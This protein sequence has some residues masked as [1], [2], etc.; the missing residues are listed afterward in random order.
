MQITLFLQYAGKWFDIYR[1]EDGV[2]FGCECVSV[3]FTPGETISMTKCCQRPT[4]GHYCVDGS[5]TVSY[6]NQELTEGRL[7]ISYFGRKFIN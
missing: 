5:A 3:N 2:S 7:N 4:T 1:Y 6:P